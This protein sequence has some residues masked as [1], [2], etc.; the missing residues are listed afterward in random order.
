M[1]SFLPLE[2]P[3]F[4][5]NIIVNNRGLILKFIS[6]QTN[7]AKLALLTNFETTLKPISD[8]FKYAKKNNAYFLRQST[9]PIALLGYQQI[10]EEIISELPQTT[11]VF[12][13]VGSGTTLLG[14]S[15]KLPSNVKIFAVQPANFNPIASVFDSNFIPENSSLTD[16]L[17]V[18]LLPLKTKVIAV[19]NQ[20]NGSGLVIQNQDI[21]TT[22]NN[23][24][25]NN[26]STS[27]EGAMALGAVTKAKNRFDIGN[28]PVV[29]LTG[30]KR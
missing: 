29:I 19:I 28:F 4:P 26:I 25:Q 23:L 6:P 9:D 8:A 2:M 10:G 3:P 30:T 1:P 18:K 22:L 20:S 16:A 24:H 11:S 7:P 27:A 5:L 15:Q 12:I 14:I 17:G 13:P 21:Q